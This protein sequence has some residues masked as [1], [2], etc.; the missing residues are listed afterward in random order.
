M[1]QP[2]GL[3]CKGGLNTNLNQLEMLSQPGF[4]TQLRN[5]EVDPDGGYRRI[6]GFEPFGGASATRP[7]GTE[8]IL[9][10]QPYALGVVACA[11]TSVYYTEDG[12]SW[13]QINYNTGHTGVTQANLSSQTELDRPEQGQA[14]FV[15]MKATEGH[16]TNPYGT[17]TIATQGGDQVAHFHIDGI[18][19]TRLFVY[20]ELTLPVAGTYVE[21]HD[22]HLCIV[23]A[24]NA[25]NVL[26]YS[27]TNS[28]RDFTGVGSGAVTFPD[29]IV[30]IKSFRNSL[31]LF[32]NNSIHKLDNINDVTNI[33]S[34]Q[35]TRN[36]GCL[37]GYS[38]QEIGGDLVFL[39]PDGI[40]T[41]AGTDRIGDVELG[42]VSRQIQQIT[43]ELANSISSYTITSAVLRSKSQYRLFYSLAGESSA[44]ARGIIGTFT[45]NGFEWSETLGIQAFGFVSDFDSTNIEKV[46]H[47]DKDGYVYLHDTGN[48]FNP[49]GAAQDIS[50]IYQT[51]NFDFGDIGTR[52][53]VKYVRLSLS[54]EGV[55]RPSFRVRYDYESVDIPQPPDY[56]LNTIPLPSLLGTAV[57]GIG[58]FGGTNDP[59]VRQAVEG[60]GNSVSFKIFSVDQNAPYSINGLYIDYMPSGRR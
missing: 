29:K 52:K 13:T 10:L 24:L 46:Y 27:K 56:I 19:A 15:L 4:A 40:R 48:A 44:A 2:F 41:V 5:F 51:P 55:I 34:T 18:G 59:M 23:D 49:A 47:G 54:P 33:Q 38:I 25:P 45:P 42:S 22:K 30:G 6:N 53:T 8:P 58:S 32:C 7:E 16:A 57:F 31:F 17:L 36:V 28:D 21:E 3:S 39:S 37:S 11:G 12:I 60:S 26:Y 35:V 20:E 1:S 50:A 43:S 14:Q 9:G